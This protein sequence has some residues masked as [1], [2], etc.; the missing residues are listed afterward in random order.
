MAILTL[1]SSKDPADL[2][3]NLSGGQYRADHMAK[4]TKL[5]KKKKKKHVLLPMPIPLM[6]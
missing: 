3:S 5:K 1:Y 6:G 2:L 4:I